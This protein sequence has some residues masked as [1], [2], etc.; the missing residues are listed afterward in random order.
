[1]G[2]G[3]WRFSMRRVTGRVVVAGMLA[4]TGLY[5]LVGPDRYANLWINF[6][7]L[8]VLLIAS[9][10]SGDRAQRSLPACLAEGVVWY[11]CAVQVGNLLI[12]VLGAPQ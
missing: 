4:G 1:M 7:L 5:A 11:L 8:C 12:I 6:S 2:S 10:I 3:D 9:M